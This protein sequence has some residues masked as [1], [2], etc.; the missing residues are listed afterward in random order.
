MTCCSGLLVVSYRADGRWHYEE[1]PYVAGSGLT[2]V[3]QANAAHALVVGY[4]GLV[5]NYGYGG[6][7]P[8]PWLTSI[9]VPSPQPTA[10]SGGFP[11]N[12]TLLDQELLYR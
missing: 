2:A 12:G 3:S 10:P 5:M 6:Q 9:P 4:R 1:A 8:Q 11:T 7:T